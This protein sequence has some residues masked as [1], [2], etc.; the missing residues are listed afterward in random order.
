[1]IKKIWR[2]KYAVVCDECGCETLECDDVQDAINDAKKEG[3][4]FTPRCFERDIEICPT[5]QAVHRP[6]EG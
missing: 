5:C 1:M 4:K 3:W 6:K 2:K